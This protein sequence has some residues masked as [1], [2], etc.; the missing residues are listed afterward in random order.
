MQHFRARTGGEKQGDGE[1]A[2]GMPTAGAQRRKKNQK[3]EGTERQQGKKEYRVQEA[4][5]KRVPK[6]QSNRGGRG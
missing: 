5:A 1:Q 6:W 2:L 4:K 3:T